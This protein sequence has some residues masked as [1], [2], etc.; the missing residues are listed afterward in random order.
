MQEMQVG[1]L[2]WEDSLEKEMT[3][4]S[5]ILRQRRLVGYSPWGCKTVRRDQVTKE[6]LLLY[7]V[8]LV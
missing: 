7:W 2:G 6:Q 1:P 8:I 3:A 4:H 5:S